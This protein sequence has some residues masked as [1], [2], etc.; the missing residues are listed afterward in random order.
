MECELTSIK[1]YSQPASN[2]CANNLFRL[3]ASGVVWVEGSK[4][5]PILF[6]MVESIPAFLPIAKNSLKRR[7]TVVVF[8]LV[9]VMP[10]SFN[11]EEGFP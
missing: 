2:I 5:S 6:S 3:T 9:P 4:V 7:L 8:P 1:T 11:L 10:T